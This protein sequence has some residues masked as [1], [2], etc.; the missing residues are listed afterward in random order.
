MI[1]ESVSCLRGRCLAQKRQ[2]ECRELTIS[3]TGKCAY[4]S[5]ATP[6]GTAYFLHQMTTSLAAFVTAVAGTE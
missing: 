2:T 6:R 4:F 5:L 1:G 3:L